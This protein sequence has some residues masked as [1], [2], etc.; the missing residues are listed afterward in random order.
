MRPFRLA[1]FA[2]SATPWLTRAIEAAAK[3]VAFPLELGIWNFTSPLAVQT[4]LKAFEPDMVFFWVNPLSARTQAL[5]ELAPLL[6]LP[7]AW[8]IPN[9]PV[10]DDGCFG[11]YALQ[12]PTSLRSRLY[13]WNQALLALAHARSNLA[14]LDLEAIVARLGHR[15][16]FDA[17]LWEAAMIAL[18]PEASQALAEALL[19]HLQ[20][21]CGKLKKVLVTDLDD[22]L[23]S[24]IVSDCGPQAIEPQ[25]PGRACYH[26]WL[27][28]LSQRGILL[29]IASRNDLP[30][31]TASFEREDLPFSLDDFSAVEV[32]WDQPKSAM[33]QAIAERLG[34]HLDSLVFIDD[35]PENRAEVRDRLPM[36]EVPELPEDPACW[37]ETLSALTCFETLTLTDDDLLRAKSLKADHMRKAQVAHLSPEAYIQSLEQ[38]LTPIPLA[39]QHYQRAAQLSQR[40]NRFNMCASRLTVQD[41]QTAK[42]WVYDLKDKYGEMGLVSLVVLKENEIVT[43]VLS[44]RAF[45]RNIEAQILNH[46]KR[47]VPNLCGR[48]VPTE[49]NQ[50]CASLYQQ[51]GVPPPCSNV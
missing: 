34:V 18:T 38:V 33:L 28:T 22:T 40:C 45:G 36:V 31:V 17:R 29:A 16:A 20:A 23:W 39:P 35:R 32:H 2:D 26:A 4:D 5:P 6:A 14:I 12:A 47:E 8:I 49:R 15:V 41:L 51:H 42:G 1:I 19:A 25:A 7:Y 37:M 50:L 10:L 21:R 27:K 11:S 3:R 46:L 48:Y 43:W 24:G 9:L 44:C 30:T 13:Q